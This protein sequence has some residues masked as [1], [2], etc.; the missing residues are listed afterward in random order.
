MRTPTAAHHAIEPVTPDAP[1]RQAA[2]T[3]ARSAAAERAFSRPHRPLALAA[4]MAV[5]APAAHAQWNCPKPE[6]GPVDASNSVFP[7]LLGFEVSDVHA[8]KFDPDGPGPKTP[9]LVVSG[10]FDLAG[11][12]LASNIA[13]I[14]PANGQWSALGEGPTNGIFG[15]GRAFADLGDGSMI[16]GGSFTLAGGVDVNHLARWDGAT[17]SDLGG[18]VSGGPPGTVGIEALLLES[19]GLIYAA[20]NFTTA[21][22]VAANRVARWDGA[23]WSPLGSGIGG[24]FS[25]IVR[26]LTQMPDGSIIA[27]GTFDTA[28][29]SGAG[30]IASWN[31]ISWTSLGGG[32]SH[33]QDYPEVHALAAMPDG[34]LIVGGF[35]TF[36]N[37]VFSPNIARWADGLWTSIGGTDGRVKAFAPMPDG[38]LLA[39]GEFFSAGGVPGTA[40]YALWDGAA[41][42]PLGGTIVGSAPNT[43]TPWPDGTIF[44]GGPSDG[45]VERA[46]GLVR[47][48]PGQGWRL[49]SAALNNT[50]TALAV[51]TTDSLV[52]AGFFASIDGVEASRIARRV[53][54]QWEPLGTGVECTSN[55]CVRDIAVLPS[56]DLVVGGDIA[57]AGQT[58]VNRIAR[59]DGSSWH[60]LGQ[61]LTSSMGFGPFVLDLEIESRGGL[62]VAGEFTHA[63]GLPANRVARWQ[64]GVW[65]TFGVGTD[66]P[67]SAILEM[68]NGDIIAAGIF[69][70][71]GS[72]TANCIARWNEQAWA[73]LG[74]GIGG[75]SA[76]VDA[77]LVQPSGDL[78]VGGYF[79]DAGGVP[80]QNIARWN[81]ESWSDL[82]GGLM[83]NF[84]YGVTELMQ[85]G[86]GEFIAAGGFTQS[87]SVPISKIARWD[88]REWW[89][90]GSGLSLSNYGPSLSVVIALA[91]TSDGSVFAG[92]EFGL[93]GGK[94]SPFLARY[95]CPATR[96]YPDCDASGQLNI[97]DFICFQ[98]NFVLGEMSADCDASGQ[99]NI[100]D[101]ICFQTLFVL[102]C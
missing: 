13:L 47:W 4:L 86:S 95:G 59:W 38:V 54:G 32:L 51:D 42:T 102:G 36:A 2:K 56:G 62:L 5:L 69:S 64:D 15:Y 8:W 39:A 16:V 26:A 27:A 57:M 55:L 101:F 22:G 11:S 65:T 98:T 81:G 28:G 12:T 53:N 52:A 20:G 31:G 76:A 96:C 90:L 75:F 50:I 70:Q 29:G 78:I 45:L 61:G 40:R 7:G 58:P 43:L 73:P 84:F 33:N 67:V 48:L 35:F 79:T 89:P 1:G 88:G 18:G 6:W 9:V 99:L 3:T 24:G 46:H 72:V 74:T 44:A 41:W 25:P 68:P 91:R 63:G 100:D 10:L 97:D 92:G 60:T 17:W 71:A 14:D 23:Q 85:L 82:G 34:S 80:V 21:G 19:S 77:L 66:G 30:N 87:A 94:A 83:G 93:A 49:P 37:G